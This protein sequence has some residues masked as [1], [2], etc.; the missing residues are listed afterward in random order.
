MLQQDTPCYTTLQPNNMAT[1]VNLEAIKAFDT[2]IV[3]EFDKWIHQDD[4]KNGFHLTY[5]AR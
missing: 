4:H 1:T 3:I 5:K 2:T